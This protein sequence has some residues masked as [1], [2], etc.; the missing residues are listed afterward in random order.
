MAKAGHLPWPWPS[1]VRPRE[2]VV[3]VGSSLD[4][5]NKATIGDGRQPGGKEKKKRKIGDL[6]LKEI[7]QL[8][9]GNPIDNSSKGIRRRW[10]ER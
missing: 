8:T 10:K 3:G 2:A 5:Q 9:S 7:L 6:D 4:D 1:T